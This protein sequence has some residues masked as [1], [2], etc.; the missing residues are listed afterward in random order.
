MHIR[1][2]ASTNDSFA[3][4]GSPTKT[5]L[6]SATVHAPRARLKVRT[7][8]PIENCPDSEWSSLNPEFVP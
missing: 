1:I 6:T 8:Y 7:N 5:E 4:S 3:S 2:R